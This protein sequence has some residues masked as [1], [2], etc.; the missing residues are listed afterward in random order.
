MSVKE[1]ILE[2][3]ACDAC[4]IQ[5]YCSNN[6][7]V[8]DSIAEAMWDAVKFHDWT[9]NDSGDLCDGCTDANTPCDDSDD[10]PGSVDD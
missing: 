6:K 8:A 9:C 1:I 2:V 4:G 3:I 7:D 10:I 5:F